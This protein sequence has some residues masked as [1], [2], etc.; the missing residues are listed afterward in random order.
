MM[1]A[2]SAALLIEAHRLA[3]QGMSPGTAGKFSRALRLN[4]HL[5]ALRQHALRCAPAA[6]RSQRCFERWVRFQLT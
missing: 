2:H 3:R 1:A 6:L 5:P 4:F